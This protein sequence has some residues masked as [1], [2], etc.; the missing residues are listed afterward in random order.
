MFNLMFIFSTAY[1]V[2]MLKR[3]ILLLPG[4]NMFASVIDN[5]DLVTGRRVLFMYY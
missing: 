1:V 2:G 4:N 5:K 3:G